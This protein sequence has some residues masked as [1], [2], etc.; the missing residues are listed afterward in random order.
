[1]YVEHHDLA[2]EFPEFK[3][4]IH[5]LKLQDAHFVKLF[6]E[7]QAVDK[8]VCRLE[9]EGVPVVDEAFEALKKQRLQLKD[10][11]YTM[12]KSVSKPCCGSCG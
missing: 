2:K 9:G 11:L 1:M 7:Y 4:E 8:E 5:Q 10:Q 12:L 6:G 3:E